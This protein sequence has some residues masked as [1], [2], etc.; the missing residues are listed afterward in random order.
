M[1]RKMFREGF[2]LVE[3][4]LS[5]A[6]I[7]VLSVAIVLIISNTISSYR[8]GLTLNMINTNGMGIVDDM[9]SALQNSTSKSVL[10]LCYKYYNNDS[11]AR[12]QCVND[13]GYSFVAHLRT[14][15]IELNEGSTNDIIEDAPLYGVFCT[16]SYSYVWNTGY[17]NTLNSLV[18]DWAEGEAPEYATFSMKESKD[19][20]K[21]SY[22]AVDDA[23][24]IQRV[25]IVGSLAGYYNED[26]SLNLEKNGDG[27]VGNPDVPFRLLK[28]SDPDRAVCASVVRNTYEGRGV[29]RGADEADEDLSNDFE[30]D[31]MY[32]KINLSNVP[33]DLILADSDNDLAL[34][35]LAVAR[36][37]ESVTRKNSFYSLSFILG[38]IRG[39]VNIKA[40]GK[41]CKTPSDGTF[42][43]FDYCAINKFS[44]AVQA[45]GE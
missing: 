44:F 43:E 27:T 10:N 22:D 28:I 29:Y 31:E 12:E 21:L 36:P 33:V 3:L 8:R 23:G 5:M 25:N 7:G 38:T 34:Y 24:K 13:G 41:N 20:A 9:R 39:G 37:A 18:N 45:G 42:D 35:D 11:S 15:D 4:S 16:G 26:G 2:T 1:N 30:M 40:Q 14:G 17:Y 6:F 32:T 19:W